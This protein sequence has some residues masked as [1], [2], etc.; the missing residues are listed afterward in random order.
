VG[1]GP[2]SLDKMQNPISKI[3][4]EKRTRGMAQAVEHLPG[5]CKT[6]SSNP[7]T[8]KIKVPYRIS[9]LLDVIVSHVFI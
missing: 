9:E 4:Q 2:G 7:N 6:L 8:A 3:T 1:G 5:K